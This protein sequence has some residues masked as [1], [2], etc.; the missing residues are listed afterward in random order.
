MAAARGPG[1]A[2]TDP[3]QQDQLKDLPAS[4]GHRKLWSPRQNRKSSGKSFF[5]GFR[6]RKSCGSE[7][8]WLKHIGNSGSYVDFRKAIS[9]PFPLGTVENW[10]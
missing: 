8:D 6:K 1:G 9:K 7:N 4:P 3:E 10:I 5:S 2:L